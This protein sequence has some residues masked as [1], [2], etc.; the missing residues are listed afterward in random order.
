LLVAGVID[1]GRFQRRDVGKVAPRAVEVETI[2]DD[3]R[4]GNVESYEV[5]LERHR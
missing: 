1:V 5:G 3:E 2:P 4:V